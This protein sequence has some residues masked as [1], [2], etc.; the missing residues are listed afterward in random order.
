ME[1]VNWK[2]GLDE[3]LSC[4]LKHNSAVHTVSPYSYGLNNPI[5]NIDNEGNFVIE[6]TDEEKEMLQKFVDAAKKA[7]STNPYLLER[8]QIHSGLTS[9]EI[10]FIFTDGKGPVLN[11]KSTVNNAETDFKNTSTEYFLKGDPA[12]DKNSVTISINDDFFKELFT[13]SDPHTFF[14]TVTILHELVHVG[15][16]KNGIAGDL[17]YEELEKTGVFRKGFVKTAEEE[18]KQTL[19]DNPNVKIEVGKAFEVDIAG[20]DVDNDNFL[21]TRLRTFESNSKKGNKRIE[22]GGRISFPSP[23]TIDKPKNDDSVLGR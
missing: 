15:D 23:P 19:K 16:R 17:D 6:G 9:D 20:Y 22:N 8:F 5:L 10:D 14:I 11:F 4:K 13:K 3:M 7:L 12:V 2:R 1:I 21:N 18:S